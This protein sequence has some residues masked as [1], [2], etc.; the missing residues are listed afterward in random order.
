MTGPSDRPPGHDDET[1]VAEQVHPGQPGMRVVRAAFVLVVMVVIGILVLPSATRGPK[2]PT[3]ATTASH[4]STP[5]PPTTST[6][7]P[8]TTTTVP[9]VAHSSIVVLVANGTSSA[10]GAGTVRSWLGTHGFNITRFPAYD[11]TTPESADAV[12]VVGNGT[13]T[14]A[15]E[16]AAALSLGPG[17]VVPVG[18]TPPVPT[19][20]GA[21]IVVVLGTDLST[22][23]SNGTLGKPP[24]SNNSTTTTT[25]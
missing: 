11:T 4:H 15:D 9:T 16:V 17:V 23:A 25:S 22:R 2:L 24:A 14:M 5:P 18:E 20:T 3:T 8:T 6:T 12:Y 19:T 1:P 13:P 21:D 7:R 10:D